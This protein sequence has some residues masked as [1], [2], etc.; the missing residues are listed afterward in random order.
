MHHAA[1][2]LNWFAL[3]L[4]AAVVIISLARVISRPGTRASRPVLA[5]VWL[6]LFVLIEAGPRLAGW[7][8]GV[9]LALSVL[10]FA[11]LLLGVRALYRR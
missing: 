8:S 6:G 10:A 4:N 11:P 7:P 9:V 5:R 1:T 2:V 3:M